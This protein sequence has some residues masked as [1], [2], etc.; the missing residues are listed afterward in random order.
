M[1]AASFQTI[2]AKVRKIHTLTG[3]S[4]ISFVICKLLVLHPALRYVASVT[5]DKCIH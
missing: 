5:R 1:N 2:S 3:M 4:Q